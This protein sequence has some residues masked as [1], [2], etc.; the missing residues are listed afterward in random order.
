VLCKDCYRI[1]IVLPRSS[2]R[3]FRVGTSVPVFDSRK[4]FSNCTC[5][6]LYCRLK[7]VPYIS[8]PCYYRVD[9]NDEDFPFPQPS[10]DDNGTTNYYL[11]D[12]ASLL[13][14]EALDVKP[15]EVVLVRIH[16]VDG[17]R[18]WSYST[19]TNRHNSFSFLHARRICAPLLEASPCP[20]YSD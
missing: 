11:L 2:R 16:Q 1:N 9:D 19:L 18:E 12:A 13:A 17:F 3:I 4:A 8:I 20:F 15:H 14:T 5:F 10:R 6:L 7:Q